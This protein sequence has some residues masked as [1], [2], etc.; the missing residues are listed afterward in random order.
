[1]TTLEGAPL[2]TRKRLSSATHLSPP[3]RAGKI[4][5]LQMSQL[6]KSSRLVSQT[7]RFAEEFPVLSYQFKVHAL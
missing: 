1:V 4:H 6:R 3:A 2:P 7:P 5:V